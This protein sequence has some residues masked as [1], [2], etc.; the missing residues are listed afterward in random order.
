LF[1]FYGFISSGEEDEVCLFIY[2]FIRWPFY[3]RR[4]QD[5]GYVP[6][7]GAGLLGFVPSNAEFIIVNIFRWWIFPQLLT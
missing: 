5:I 3:E 1:R 6:F 2:L 4:I 7:Y